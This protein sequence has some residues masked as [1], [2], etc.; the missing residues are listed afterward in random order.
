[1]GGKYTVYLDMSLIFLWFC[2][3]MGN[4]EVQPVAN[5]WFRLALGAF[6]GAPF[7]LAAACL[8]FLLSF[9]IKVLFSVAMVYAAFPVLI[10]KVFSGSAISFSCFTMG[11]AML[12]AI[13]LI[14]KEQISMVL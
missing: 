2:S 7:L 10:S 5:S 12:G 4:G 9:S 8:H 3:L 1:M 14:S 11:G 13:Y 6:V